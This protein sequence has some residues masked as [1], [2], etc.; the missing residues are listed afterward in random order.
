[1]KLHCIFDRANI[2]YPFHL[3]DIEVGGITS[4]SNEVKENYIFVCLKGTKNDGH[5]YLKTAFDKGAV[6]AVI[7]NDKFSNEALLFFVYYGIIKAFLV[8]T[9][10]KV[11]ERI[12][13]WLE[14]KKD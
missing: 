14:I 6:V 11:Q 1:M 13:L 7:E 9:R 5:N 8:E 4:R 2:K 12:K 10:I 3:K